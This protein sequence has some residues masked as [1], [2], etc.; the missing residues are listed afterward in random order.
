MVVNARIVDLIR[1]G[2]PEHI[3]EAIAE[4]AFVDMQN[5]TQA[6]TRLVLDGIV[7]RDVAA[8]AA[9]NAHDFLIQLDHHLR[10]EEAERAEESAEPAP[11]FA[12]ALRR[13]GP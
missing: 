5:F 4:G 12:G 6:L 10:R 13:V 2:R 1:E 11:A 3:S 8:G 9:S 7:D